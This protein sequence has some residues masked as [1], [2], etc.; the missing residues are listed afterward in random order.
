MSVV[1]LIAVVPVV[2]E[3]SE[4]PTPEAESV[5]PVVVTEEEVPTPEAES[6]IPVVVTEEEVPIHFEARGVYSQLCG[7]CV[8]KGDQP[9]A[10]AMAGVQLYG[11]YLP[12]GWK[13]GLGVLRIGPYG[14]LS[15][16][17]PVQKVAAGLALTFRP[18]DEP[19]EIFTQT[20]IRY[21]SDSIE[22]PLSKGRKGS[23]EPGAY[24]LALG[25]RY[26]FGEQWYLSFVGEHDSNGKE[27]GINF[28][29]GKSGTNPGIDSAMFGI[30]FLTSWGKPRN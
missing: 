6:V 1:S 12:I 27:L 4:V 7:T 20:G 25:V 8:L 26:Y 22:Y 13:T 9:P 11:D 5:I 21:T 16:V 10:S 29:P 15:W 17:G 18:K 19:F 24:N 3:S 30:G 14:S 28:F 23:Q 2:V